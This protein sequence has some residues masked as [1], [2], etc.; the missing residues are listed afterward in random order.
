MNWLQRNLPSRESWAWVIVTLASVLAYL[1]AHFEALQSAFE[2]APVWE[3][4]IELV[5]GLLAMLAAKQTFSWMPTKARQEQA[6]D[7]HEAEKSLRS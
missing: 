4:R 2:L 6:Q 7:A 5:A 3:K 1:S